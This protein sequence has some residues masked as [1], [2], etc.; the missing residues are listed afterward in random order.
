VIAV[1]LP[2]AQVR[3][4]ERADGDLRDPAVLER[5]RAELGL[6]RIVSG[7]QPHGVEIA[8]DDREADGRLTRAGNVGCLVFVADCLPVALSGPGVVAMVHAGWGGL[9]AG[10]LEAGVAATGATHAVI[11]PGAGPCCYE[12]GPEVHEAFG[13]APQRAR[14]DLKALAAERL[15][16]INVQ[17]LGICTICSPDYFSYRRD[18]T[19]ERQGGV[20]WRG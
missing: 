10:V 9:A 3:F 14:I 19:Q 12:V 8:E 18:G 11:G 5:L 1:A 6:E 16:G 17:D 7:K 20:V 15:R 13:L 2:G 4:T